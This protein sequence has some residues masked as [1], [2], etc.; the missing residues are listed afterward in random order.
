MFQYFK[1]TGVPMAQKL[2][3]YF[4]FT[5]QLSRQAYRRYNLHQLCEGTADVINQIGIYRRLAALVG[6]SGDFSGSLSAASLGVYASLLKVYRYI[7][8]ELADGGS[9]NLLQEASEKAGC[10]PDAPEFAR[11]CSLFRDL[12]P[13]MD[14]DHLPEAVQRHLVLRELLLLDLAHRNPALEHFRQLFDDQELASRSS[15]RAWMSALL[16]TL[17]E[18]FVLPEVGVTL[19]GALLAPLAIYPA[20]L[21]DQLEYLRKTWGAQLPPTLIEQ[22]LIA[23]DLLQEEE[24][25]RHA[26][27]PG[28]TQVLEFVGSNSSAP[29]REPGG[30]AYGAGHHAGYDQP[31]YEA[32]SPDADWMSHVVMIAKMTHVWLDQLTKQYGYPVSR[33]D[34]VPDAELDLLA[35]RGFTGLWLIGVWERSPASRRIKQLC[36]N[37]DAHASAYSLFDYVV[38]EDLGGEA[39]LLNLKERAW[40]RGIRLAS[41][42]V[43]NHTGIYSRWI[44]EHPDWFVQADQMPFPTYQFSGEDLSH[45]PA[46][47]IQ[48]EDGYWNRQ[49]AAVVFR[50][51]DRR[52]GERTRY[53]YHG[54]DGTSIPWNDTAQLNYLLPQVREAVIQTI[55]HVAR[56]TPII[57][58]DAAMTLA[59]KHYQRLWFPQRGLGGGIPSR[60]EYAMSRDEFDSVFPVEFWREVVDRV[61][62]EAPGTLLLA[63]AFWLMEG[64]FVRT[65]G[66]HRVYN[67]AFM[68]MLKQEENE[69]YRQT[70]KNVL[71]FNPEILKRFV[72][73]MN[74]PD[75]KTAVEQFGSQGKY[76]GASALLATMPGLP[77]FGHGQLEGFREKY[78]MEYRRAYWEETVDEG[79]MRGHE[80]WI[81]PLLKRRWLFSGSENFALY[82][83]TRHDGLIDEHVFAYSNRSGDQRALIL[84]NNCYAQTAG[85]IRHAAPSAETEGSNPPRLQTL[86][87]GQALD[88][89]DDQNR[90][91]V[92]RDLVTG[93]EYLRNC[94]ELHQAGLYTELAEYG[95][96][97]FLDFRLISAA[98]RDSVRSLSEQLAGAGVASVE[99]E[100]IQLENKDILSAFSACLSALEQ[101]VCSSTERVPE[102][103]LADYCDQ[104]PPVDRIGLDTSGLNELLAAAYDSVRMRRMLR[105]LRRQGVSRSD[106]ACT[107]ANRKLLVAVILVRT[108]VLALGDDAVKA[109]GFDRL[110]VAYIGRPDEDLQEVTRWYAVL[111]TALAIAWE[112]Q[113]VADSG[114][115]AEL[116]ADPRLHEFLLVHEDQQVIWFNKERF[117]ILLCWL[118]LFASFDQA[119]GE[120]VSLL[121]IPKLRE[122]ARLSGYRLQ[123]LLY[124]LQQDVLSEG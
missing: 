10:P 21:S 11:C 102:T 122:A 107:P 40:R 13:A 54:N 56:L 39:G 45:D 78:G 96:Q 94:A 113:T 8:D 114:Q 19:G 106:L 112:Q 22:V 61:A 100:L 1:E 64:Y 110:L 84:Y 87:L 41:D 72:N 20:S 27:G 12:F 69:K 97:L 92:F 99:D 51:I 73:F 62:Q 31:E 111:C 32:F 70:I 48:I 83:V 38:A 118:A 77:M 14:I 109:R 18:G 29:I 82:D 7:F 93:L 60:A 49:D 23:F 71:A 30:M 43:P 5:I 26:G 4:P 34:Q 95:L 46:V 124:M 104:L 59:K 120:Q 52:D 116:F 117:D 88:L 36:G 79:L 37:P 85:W 103:V 57:R 108:L 17:Q 119:R 2:P 80:L 90:F 105:G 101:Q 33:L 91:V 89:P 6:R 115:L 65:L 81:F 75:E 55:L 66:M 47:T 121:Q 67:S 68:N 74:N 50:M 58:F 25:Q 53:I 98:A 24:Q 16:Q 15:Y 86:T 3:D 76:F 42:M 35:R 63:E 28:P 123:R 9:Y 44:L